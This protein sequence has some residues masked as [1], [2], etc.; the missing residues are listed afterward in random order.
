[1]T[2][3]DTTGQKKPGYCA[4]IFNCYT[5]CRPITK[6]QQQ[7]TTERMNKETGDMSEHKTTQ[8][9]IADLPLALD[10]D[11]FMRRLIRE[12]A[13][14]LE[15]VVGLEHASGFIAVVGQTLGEQINA[16]YRAALQVSRLSREQVAS[17]LV[18]LKQRIEGD[19]SVVE[20]NDDKIVLASRSC[21][22]GDCVKG[23]KSMC[24]MTSN[25][26][27]TIAADN[28][29]YAKVELC[30]TIAGG[31]AQCRVV[32]HLKRSKEA[33]AADGLEYLGEGA[34]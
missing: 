18:D 9:T 8:Q 26:F 21:P 20:Q 4:T 25:V 34:T 27:G 5:F 24:M 7:L 14:T 30:Q 3:F 1:M 6:S 29:G 19:F 23:R 13:G 12:L 28:L 2:E 17:V 15:E 10:R 31:D 33:D 32:V 11:R 22:F 16:D